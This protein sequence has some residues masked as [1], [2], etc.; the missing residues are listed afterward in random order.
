MAKKILEKIVDVIGF[1]GERI[2][3]SESGSRLFSGYL[4]VER[5]TG[6][7]VGGNY[8]DSRGNS[9]GIEKGG[10]CNKKRMIFT[11]VSDSGNKTYFKLNKERH[12]GDYAGHF[13]GPKSRGSIELSAYTPK[14][15]KDI[16][17][18][19]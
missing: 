4:E 5:N 12:N 13:E 7:I 17:N 9:S 6:Q 16:L 3:E 11:T 1:V 15:L 2:P 18:R 10:E 19:E 14:K 8:A